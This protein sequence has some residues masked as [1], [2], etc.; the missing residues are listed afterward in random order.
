MR[1]VLLAAFGTAKLAGRNE[2]RPDD[3]TEERAA[4]KTRIGF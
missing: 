3:I 1:R 4:K 2:V